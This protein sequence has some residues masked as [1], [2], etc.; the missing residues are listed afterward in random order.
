[1]KYEVVCIAVKDVNLFKQFYQIYMDLR[2][3]KIMV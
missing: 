3:F 1:M 2:Y